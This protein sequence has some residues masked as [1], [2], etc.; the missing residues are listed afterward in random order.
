MCSSKV[1]GEAEKVYRDN[2]G[3]RNAHG[4]VKAVVDFYK[5]KEDISISSIYNHFNEHYKRQETNIKIKEYI[6]DLATYRLSEINKRIVLED[7]RTALN[8]TFLFLMSETE[9][10][11]LD[12]VRKTT[13][14]IK[15]ISECLSSV[16]EEIRKIDEKIEPVIMFIT[17]L[18]QVITEKLKS[19]KDGQVKDT[20]HEV[21]DEMSEKMKGFIVETKKS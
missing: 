8:K 15:T 18:K 6:E 12:S 21:L 1:R 7:R 20:L 16:E 5:G 19:A 17:Y 3:D 11:S 13:V 14:A 9:G 10:Q 4:A 2:N